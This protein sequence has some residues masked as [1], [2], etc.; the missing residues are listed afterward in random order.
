MFFINGV[1]IVS[2]FLKLLSSNRNKSLTPAGTCDIFCPY[3]FLFCDMQKLRTNSFTNIILSVLHL[4]YAYFFH[5]TS[6]DVD[7]FLVPRAK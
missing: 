1:S 3:V 5:R 2:Y 7:V 4:L 6:M